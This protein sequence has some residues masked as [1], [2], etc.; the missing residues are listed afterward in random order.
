VVKPS[1]D[2]RAR[3]LH[4]LAMTAT[5]LSFTISDARRDDDPL[6][7]VNP[8]FE[9]MTGYT[10]DRVVGRN[11]R[12]LQG[13]GTDPD[14]VGR[15]RDA[16]R[17]GEPV[18]ETLLNYRADGTA[19]WNELSI[20]PVHDAGGTLVN[21]VGVQ[22]DVTARVD[23]GAQREAAHVVDRRSRSR[24]ALLADIAEVGLD[25]DSPGAVRQLADV[26]ARGLGGW[27]AV[28]VT[29]NG[30]ARLAAMAGAELPVEA[31]HFRLKRGG[32]G[33]VSDPV[34]DLLAGV[35]RAPVDVDR[36]VAF[37]DTSASQWLVRTVC[38]ATPGQCIAVGVAGRHEVLGLIV[39]GPSDGTLDTGDV[40]FLTECAR[41]VGL[42][43]DN[44]RLYAR[45]HLLAEALQRSMLPEQPSVP[46]LDVWSYYAPNLDH[47]QVGGDWYDVMQPDADSVGIVIGDV[48]GHDIE[49]AAAMGQL[50]S[51]VRAY[52]FEQEEPGTVLMRVDQLVRG[53]RIPRSASLVY[54]RLTQLGDDQW[55]M[56]WSRAGHLPPLLVSAGQVHTLSA[57]G[58]M[59]VGIGDRPRATNTTRIGPGDI[60]VFYTDG[61]IERRSRPMLDGLRALQQLCAS[62][63]P[64][65]AAGVGE[66]LLAA[67]GDAPEDDMAIVV[68]RVPTERIPQAGS[69]VPRQ[70]RWQ[71]PAEPTSIG[72]ARRLTVQTAALWGLEAAAEAELVVSELV[73]NAVLHGW[74]PVGLRLR[75]EPRGLVI[76]VDDSNPA[77]PARS[78]E[79]REGPGGFGLHVVERLAEWGWHPA[80]GGKTVW[81]R[82]GGPDDD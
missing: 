67:L 20:S 42:A 27:C 7:W 28:V 8:A 17:A 44:A 21:F 29:E 46:H 18:V 19:F 24:L 61:L 63:A 69:A 52:A 26:L 65:D 23:A 32:P 25:L 10:A 33:A 36:T 2:E 11:C 47:A 30:T 51:V 14:A 45:E 22:V 43:F 13:E 60:V 39:L 72:R 56:A 38:A 41:R 3:G 9:R 6:I 78:E 57:N 54:A 48:V 79:G 73:A 4:D 35:S 82:I 71:L 75:Y 80:G 66:Q 1:S 50:R 68:V 37:A 59:L 55:E 49:A 58:G 81:A 15:V 62:L 70:R 74:G 53:M 34:A 40:A 64:T 5:D 16:L 12:F 31:S 77:P 76:E